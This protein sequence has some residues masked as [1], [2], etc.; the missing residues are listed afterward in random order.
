MFLPPLILSAWISLQV[1]HMMISSVTPQRVDGPLQV[2]SVL[3]APRQEVSNV[4][5]KGDDLE[6]ANQWI[7]ASKLVQTGSDQF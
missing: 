5:M 7:A 3:P 6:A 2:Q 1:S 4:Q